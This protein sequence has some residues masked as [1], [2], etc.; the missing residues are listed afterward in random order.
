MDINRDNYE[1]YFLLYADNELTDSEK[2]EVLMFVKHNKD[3]EDEFRMIHYTI[4]R[5]DAS[6]HL[7]DKSFL[8][9]NDATAFIN[10]KNYEE[11]FVLYHDNELKKEQKL[12][13][14]EFVSHH[15]ELK[16]EFDLIGLAR[17]TPES[18]I[19]FNNK[20]ILYK[21]EK[22]GKVVPVLF[23]RMLAAAVFIGFGLWFT[24]LFFEKP[25]KSNITTAHSDPANNI[26]PKVDNKILPE[27][28]TSE[29]VAQY[30]DPGN[31]TQEKE[32]GD[33]ELKKQKASEHRNND[34]VVKDDIR[35]QK[36]TEENST[37]QLPEKIN[38]AIVVSNNGTRE[39]PKEETSSLN[40]INPS[41]ALAQNQ[42]DNNVEK[43]G[44]L[45][46]AKD[47]SYTEVADNKNE[48]YVFYD[49]STDKFKKTKVGG[50]LKKVKRV[51]ERSNPITRLLSGDDRQV[52][53][54]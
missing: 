16:N 40:K 9:R 54:N 1:E 12:Q 36:P 2:A 47:V 5:P 7:S 53:S 51:V 48:N 26:T 22:V 30:S 27:K 20:K 24:G 43:T 42:A 50:F 45:A 21:K 25:R 18:S 35:T 28:K 13:T 11:V 39:I 17:L 31:K 37:N 15:S 34:A 6:I 38:D 41:I 23:W 44:P 49:V 19:V 8:Y 3:L 46:N 29:S 32:T 4:A 10:E 14:E 52:V 33:K